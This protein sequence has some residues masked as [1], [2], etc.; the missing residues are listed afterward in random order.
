VP[1]STAA[2]C[3][4]NGR[5]RTT[6]RTA[7]SARTAP[8][9]NQT[10]CASVTNALSYAFTL[11]RAK[12]LSL[13]R[14]LQDAVTLKPHTRHGLVQGNTMQLSVALRISRRPMSVEGQTS[15]VPATSAWGLLTLQDSP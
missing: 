11:R 14:D 4:R 9:T 10:V 15:A 6:V 3:H 7:P 5:G 1:S 13:H 2:K 12:Q 8:T